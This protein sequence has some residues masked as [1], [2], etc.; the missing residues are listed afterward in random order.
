MLCGE[1]ECLLYLSPQEERMKQLGPG[2]LDPLEVLK[3][4]P[5]MSMTL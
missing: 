3:T 4:L 2:G 1:I 5:P